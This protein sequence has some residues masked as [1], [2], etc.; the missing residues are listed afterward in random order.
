MK[1]IE[2]TVTRLI[3]AAPADVYDV[4]TDTKSPGGPWFGADRV[5]L[6]PV[7]DGLFFHSML[8]EGKVWA[9]YGRFVRLDRPRVIEHT[10]MSEA[11]KGIETTVTVTFEPKGND[12]QITVRHAG[13]PDDEL[14]RQHRE[15]WTYML[16]AIA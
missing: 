13:V 10:W 3:P 12:T 1:Q 7:V 15:G 2:L 9:H 16:N 4:W 5:I 8:H 14:G 6:N 11:T